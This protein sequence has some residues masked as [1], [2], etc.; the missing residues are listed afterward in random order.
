MAT[1]ISSTGTNRTLMSLGEARGRGESEVQSIKNVQIIMYHN[2][3]YLLQLFT[4]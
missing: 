3:M 4:F 1:A 2:L